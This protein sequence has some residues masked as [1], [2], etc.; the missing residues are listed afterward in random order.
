MKDSPNGS[1]EVEAINRAPPP[2][3]LGPLATQKNKKLHSDSKLE[4]SPHSLR[5]KSRFLFLREDLSSLECATDSSKRTS[6]SPST[7]SLCLLLLGIQSPRR[8]G[9]ARELPRI[10]VESQKVCITLLF[11]GIDS[12]HQ[13]DLGGNLGGLGLKETRLFVSSSIET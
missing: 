5:L 9:I 6:P 10:V 13:V 4:L 1:F 12:E 3:P 7:T 8:L 2:N 11:A